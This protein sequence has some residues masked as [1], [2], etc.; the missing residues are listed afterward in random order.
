MPLAEDEPVAPL[1]CRVCRI[2]PEGMEIEGGD[3]VNGGQRAAGMPGLGAVKGLDD[4]DPEIPGLLF[5]GGDQ[6]S[7]HVC[8]FV[9]L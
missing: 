1:P 9:R 2:V 7:V 6:F 4:G 5:Q 3:E 8:S